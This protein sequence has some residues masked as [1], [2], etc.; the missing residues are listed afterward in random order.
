V[1]FYQGVLQEVVR[2]GDHALVSFPEHIPEIVAWALA[3]AQP[4]KG[5]A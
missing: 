5:A 3:S 4:R 1:A 2:G